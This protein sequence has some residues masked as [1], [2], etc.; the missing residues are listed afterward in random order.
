MK[1]IKFKFIEVTMLL[2]SAISIFSQNNWTI[3]GNG[4]TIGSTN[5]LGTTN[6]EPLNFRT[7]NTQRMN[8]RELNNL[9]PIWYPGGNNAGY[10]ALGDPSFNSPL[11]HLSV[12]T[13]S[14]N[15]FGEMLIGGSISDVP[16]SYAA[17][18]NPTTGNNLFLPTFLGYLDS[19][20]AGPAISTL[21][22]IDPINDVAPTSNNAPVH[23]FIVSK[24]IRL[25][26]IKEEFE[27]CT[28]ELNVADYKKN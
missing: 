1:S 14:L 12:Q 2:F 3:N 7:N 21:G 17:L 15:G 16:R 23:R 6:N 8:L 20:Q 27:F 13:P 26:T 4:N 9:N 18:Y 11:F 5:F 10:L 24:G 25:Y 22:N 28:K 19:S